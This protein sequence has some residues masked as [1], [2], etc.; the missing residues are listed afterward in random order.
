MKGFLMARLIF[1]RGVRSIALKRGV[2]AIT[3]DNNKKIK[4]NKEKL[5]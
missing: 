5:N 2:T 1:Y 4:K 3:T